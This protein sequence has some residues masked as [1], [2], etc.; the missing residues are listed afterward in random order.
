MVAKFNR[1]RL[2]RKYGLQI[3]ETCQIGAGLELPHSLSIVIHYNASICK[4]CTIHQF[5]TIGG[6]GYGNA[7]R[8]GDNCFIGAG[9]TI[10]GNIRI[11]DNVT[12]GANAVVVKDIPDNATVGGVPARVLHFKH[13][14]KFIK[15]PV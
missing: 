6:D 2:T 13:P 4:N 15:N 9:A 1:V 12:I 10:I 7:P 3:P 11:G 8:I 14:A 5:V